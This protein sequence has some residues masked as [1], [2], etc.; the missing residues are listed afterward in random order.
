MESPLCIIMPVG[1][2][3]DFKEMKNVSYQRVGRLSM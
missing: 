1:I 3:I 2:N